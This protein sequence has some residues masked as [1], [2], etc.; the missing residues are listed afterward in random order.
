MRK[1]VGRPGFSQ[2]S[3][4]RHASIEDDLGRTGSM[5]E[6]KRIQQARFLTDL[7]R[8]SGQRGTPLTALAQ[9]CT[10]LRSHASPQPFANIDEYN[11]YVQSFYGRQFVFMH[12]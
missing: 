5:R 7:A 11:Q 1:D 8:N 12:V 9:P 6:P 3:R 4:H 10:G 2:V